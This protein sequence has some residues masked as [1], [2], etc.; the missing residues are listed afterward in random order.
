MA[1]AAA[2]LCDY[3]GGPTKVGF[4]GARGGGKSHWMLSQLA[5]DCLRR[6]GISCL[7]LR[8]VGKS[9]KEGFEKLIRRALSGVPYK[10]VPTRNLLV[11]E[12]GSQIILGHFQ[13][14]NDVNGY[15]GLEY[16][17]IG[18]EEATTLTSSK[19]TAIETCN[20]TGLPDWRPRMYYTTNP[21]GVGHAWFK[22]LFI[23]PFQAACETFT[24]FIV[25]TVDDNA[26][27]N[28][29]YRAILDRLFGWQKKAWRFGDWD[30]AAGQFFT[31]WR[32]QIDGKPHHVIPSRLA[33]QMAL[34]TVGCSLDHGFVHYTSVHL[35]G[36]T[37]DGDLITIDEYM[38]TRKLPSQ[39]AAGIH[40]M[41]ARHGLTAAR[42]NFFVAGHDA[43]AERGGENGKTIADEYALHGIKLKPANIERIAGASEMLT[44]F[45]DA[46]SNPIIRP[47]G[48]V[49]D[50]CAR[51]IECIPALEHNPNKPEDVLKWDMDDDGEGGDDAY[52]DT[53][54][55]WMEFVERRI[56]GRSVSGGARLDYAMVTEQ[57]RIWQP[58]Q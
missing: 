29:E 3:L 30:I 16:D 46:E 39:N 45:G 42:L 49:M 44:R 32:A 4:G 40:A 50:R 26:F 41:L 1:S 8:K 37:G 51:L 35:H 31:N 17:V 2:R 6:D 54:Y 27:V 21:G 36:K 12:N 5:E 23:K 10:Y 53:R 22:S 9:L 13:H 19:H 56:D 58:G 15:L 14:E 48:F 34:R 52:D 55:G 24:R 25:S 43:F 33:S 11:F 28:V 57:Q 18:I 7:L 47:T 38:E 20:R